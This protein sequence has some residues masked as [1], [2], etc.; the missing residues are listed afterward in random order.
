MM[1]SSR[2]EHA[3][4]TL[5]QISR[6]AETLQ[7]GD[8]LVYWTLDKAVGGKMFAIMDTEAGQGHVLAFAAGPVR[9]LELLEVEGVK[10][11]P[12]LAR[13]HW[14]A[15]EDWSVF[16]GAEIARELLAAHAYIFGRMP[17]RVQR[18]QDLPTKEY[19]ALV[20]ERRATGSSKGG[21][22]RA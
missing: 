6:V 20:R 9:A 3:R 15:V 8:N 22:L 19:R 4:Q 12:Y 16:S 18:L 17:P 10:P 7:F 13:A 14:V 11:A 1:E 2:F 21:K 5:L